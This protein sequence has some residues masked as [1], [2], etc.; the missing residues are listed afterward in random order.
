MSLEVLE[1]DRLWRAT[2]EYYGSRGQQIVYLM[3]NG[4]IGGGYYWLIAHSPEQWP[5]AA[6]RCNPET[7]ARMIE[8]GK[9]RLIKGQWPDVILELLAQWPA[10][11]VAQGS[12][13]GALP[14][15][16]T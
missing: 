6:D 2:A 4:S 9:M 3:D 15:R 14:G 5:S 8:A 13:S 11:R 12:S 16:G 1:A 7:T 10:F